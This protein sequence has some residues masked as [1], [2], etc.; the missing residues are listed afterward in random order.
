MSRYFSLCCCSQVNEFLNTFKRIIS[1]LKNLDRSVEKRKEPDEIGS[2]VLVHTTVSPAG[3][4]KMGNALTYSAALNFSR[5]CFEG[6][7]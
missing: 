6:V 3:S 7:R 1:G 2:R 5:L 4:Y